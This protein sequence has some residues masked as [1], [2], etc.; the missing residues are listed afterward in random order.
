MTTC[1]VD[2]LGL[3]ELQKRLETGKYRVSTRKI[4]PK[5]CWLMNRE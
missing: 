3:F 2:T 5:R 4:Q 1:I